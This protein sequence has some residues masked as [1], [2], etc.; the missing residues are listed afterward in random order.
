MLITIKDLEKEL[1]QV[2]QNKYLETVNNTYALESPY[3]NT[4]IK[5]TNNSTTKSKQSERYL[6]SLLRK[7]SSSKV[8]CKLLRKIK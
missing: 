4:E 3:L 5:S 8:K 7:K 2:K 6:F 1:Y